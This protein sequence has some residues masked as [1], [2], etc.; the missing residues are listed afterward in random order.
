LL[1]P[2]LSAFVFTQCVEIPIYT[3]LARATLP[4]A[5]GASALTH[6]IVW[7]IIPELMQ[8]RG[9]LAMVLVAETFA[10]VAEALYLGLAFGVNRPLCW[11]LLA[12]V[13]SAGLGLLSRALLGWP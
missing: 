13:T 7:F 4:A 5:F 11:A 2:W 3:R 6:P 12:N 8:G 1:T 9:Y 10:V